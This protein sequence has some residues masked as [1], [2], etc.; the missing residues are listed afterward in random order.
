MDI[1]RVFVVSNV[2]KKSMYGMFALL[3]CVWSPGEAA[4]MCNNCCYHHQY[5]PTKSAEQIKKENRDLLLETWEGHLLGL[6]WSDREDFLYDVSK[7]T[8]VQKQEYINEGLAIVVNIRI[9]CDY[10]LN[11]RNYAYRVLCGYCEEQGRLQDAIGWALIG[12]ERGMP[13]CA[14]YLRYAYALGVGVV[15]NYEEAMKWAYVGCALGDECC[16]KLV[17]ESFSDCS[18]EQGTCGDI[19]RSGRRLAE[20]WMD[21]HPGLFAAVRMR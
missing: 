1:E 10:T 3:A 19:T 6:G 12:V 7:L 21:E 20:I 9:D 14:S 8:E 15:Q 17:N 4:Q 11:T 2:L 16:K 5:L 13:C 18:L